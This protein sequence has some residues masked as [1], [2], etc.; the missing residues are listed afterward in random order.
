MTIAAGSPS[1]SQI[2]TEPTEWSRISWATL[3]TS[4]SA[5]AVTTPGVMI[6]RSCI[7]RTITRGKSE[8]F[9]AIEGD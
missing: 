1:E 4:A 8:P 3:S 5:L 6:S 2:T 7:G 9:V